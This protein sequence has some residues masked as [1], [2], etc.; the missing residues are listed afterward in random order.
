MLYAFFREFFM[1]NSGLSII[2]EKEEVTS[3]KNYIFGKN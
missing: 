1:L 2:Y 3:L